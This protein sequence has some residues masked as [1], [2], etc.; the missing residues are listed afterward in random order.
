MIDLDDM[1]NEI[2]NILGSKGCKEQSQVDF[3]DSGSSSL[4]ESQL[5][6]NICIGVNVVQDNPIVGNDD[7][8]IATTPPILGSGVQSDPNPIGTKLSTLGNGVLEV[9]PASKGH[10]ENTLPNLGTRVSS[11]ILPTQIMN[12]KNTILHT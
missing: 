4:E 6:T 2:P 8:T 3:F 1:V 5:A 9:L 7:N 12:V 11:I 10:I